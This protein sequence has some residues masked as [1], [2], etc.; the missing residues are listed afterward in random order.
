MV[1]I[2][3]DVP[4]QYPKFSWFCFVVALGLFV[5][6]ARTVPAAANAKETLLGAW[7]L[8]SIEY[9]G[10][11]GHLPD[12]VFGLDPHGVIIYDR[13]GWMSVQIFTANR[14]TMT[15]PAS[16]TSGE[17]SP[18]DAQVKSK[19]FDTYYAYFGTWEYDATTSTVTHHLKS[20]LLP[21]ETGQDYQRQVEL[22]G[23]RLRLTARMGE[24]DEA[25]RRTLTWERVP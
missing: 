12:P 13:S 7:H 19:A 1:T 2:I 3:G 9:S 8:V 15:R 5:T 23:S 25:R 20:S 18:D 16:R 14:P 4:M 6:Q 10:P 21:Y 22:Q 24:G 11:T 17:T